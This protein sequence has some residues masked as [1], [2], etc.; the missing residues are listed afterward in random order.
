MVSPETTCSRILT[1]LEDLVAQEGAVLHVGD[2][3]AL[4]HIQT[5]ARTLIDFLSAQPQAALAGLGERLQSLQATRRD[6][7]ARLEQAMATNRDEL[8]VIS[9]RQGLIARVA[10][11]Y[12]ANA[13]ALRQ[14]SLVA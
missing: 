10:P 1:A 13:G 5:H 12:G 4:E 11:A 8:R 3:G 14:I 6:H 7:A 9:A 2:F